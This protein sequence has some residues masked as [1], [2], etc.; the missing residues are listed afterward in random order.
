M[1]ILLINNLY[2]VGEEFTVGGVEYHRMMKPHN[3]LRRQFPE[4]DLIMTGGL[5]DELDEYL[6][7][8]DL[9]V[10]SRGIDNPEWAFNKLAS[11]N[12]PVCLDLDDYWH[13][14][15]YHVSFRDYQRLKKAKNTIECIKR[16]AFVTC[17]TPI[18]A[19]K[20]KP[21]NPNVY[22]IENGIDSEDQTW[23]ANKTQSNRLRFGFTQGNTHFEDIR[24]ISKDVV[25]A[26]K[27]DQFYK[28]G[29]II[30]TGF[31]GSHIKQ[32]QEQ[33]IQLLL[34]DCYK[35]IRRDYPNH[36]HDLRMFRESS[37]DAPYKIIWGRDVKEF[38]NV[39]NDIDVSIVPLLNNEFT[40][41]KSELKMLEAAA[42]DCAIILSH[43][44]PYTL[45]ATDKNSFDLKKKPFNEWAKYLLNNPN[46]LEDS[47][48]QLK[49]DVKGYD[50]KELSKKR[51]EIY[52]KFLTSRKS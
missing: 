18:L 4:V 32:T 6:K 2:Q 7:Q 35:T 1:N 11:F 26:L 37:V 3:V 45:L 44:E 28:Q 46:A 12:I 21:F 36:V 42:K 31:A 52:S 48:A 15:P 13:L 38:G 25:K 50:L 27:D 8:T 9:A 29:Q 17:T 19:E 10:I 14:P 16:A 40:S 20:I 24:S 41:C 49:E 34:T 47:K 33:R 51:K 23:Q 22:V 43:V 30:Q 5:G 39:Y